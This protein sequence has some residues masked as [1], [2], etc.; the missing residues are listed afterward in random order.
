MFGY[1]T[2]KFEWHY[3]RMMANG[4]FYHSLDLLLISE[5]LHAE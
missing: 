4:E 2:P 5:N 1:M 3:Q